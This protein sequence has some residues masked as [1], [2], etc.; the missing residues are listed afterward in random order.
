MFNEFFKKHRLDENEGMSLSR[1]RKIQNRVLTRIE[2]EPQKALG[3]MYEPKTALS[4]AVCEPQEVLSGAVYEPKTALSGAKPQKA[5]RLSLVKRAAAAALA[6]AV[7]I[8]A[9]TIGAFTSKRTVINGIE[10]EPQ[11]TVYLDEDGAKVEIVIYPVPEEALGEEIEGNTPVGELR[12]KRFDVQGWNGRP[13][14][15]D[16]E[17]T[18]FPVSVN[19][20][21]VETIITLDG[22][23]E[24]VSYGISNIREGWGYSAIARDGYNYESIVFKES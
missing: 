5:K 4:G 23:T 21:L 16:E 14:L 3:T 6:A 10:V 20:M 18:E 22:D 13:R 2:N 17:G 1:R 8:S 24:Y 9:V 12:V 15:V 19:N 7:V 11:Y